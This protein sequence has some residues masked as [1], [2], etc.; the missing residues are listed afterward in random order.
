EE[1]GVRELC[2]PQRTSSDGQLRQYVEVGQGQTGLAFEIGLKL[3]QKRGVGPEQRVPRPQAAPARHL[4][5]H[6][7]IEVSSGVRFRR[8]LH[9]QSPESIVLAVASISI[10]GKEMADD[11][12]SGTRPGGIADRAVGHE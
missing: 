1:G 9:M 4:P 3:A 8:Y 6:D 11:Q 12:R 10:T 7:P 5:R 2:H